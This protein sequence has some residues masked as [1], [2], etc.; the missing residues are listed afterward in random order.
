[1]Q[2]F[3]SR[4]NARSPCKRLDGPARELAFEH[5]QL[6]RV[7]P[8]LAFQFFNLTLSS[9]M[10]ANELRIGNKVLNPYHGKIYTVEGFKYAR[11]P[12]GDRRAYVSTLEHSQNSVNISV[13]QPIPINEK[14]LQEAGAK[15]EGDGQWKLGSFTIK[16]GP[17]GYTVSPHKEYSISI[18]YLHDLQNLYYY[19]H[20]KQELELRKY[21]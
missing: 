11:D 18:Q 19:H 8:D 6:L 2:G 10:E 16:S 5:I 17:E 20:N 21:F 3:K 13:L 7:K 15:S 4:W 14:W 1:L 12:N 9:A